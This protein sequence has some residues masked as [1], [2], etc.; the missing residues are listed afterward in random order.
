MPLIPVHGGRQGRQI[1]EFKGSLATEQ[2]PEQPGLYSETLSQT[3]LNV[4]EL[5]GST[6]AVATGQWLP[7]R[8]AI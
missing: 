6:K 7:P 5:S 8:K 2:V 3:K 1:S 4:S